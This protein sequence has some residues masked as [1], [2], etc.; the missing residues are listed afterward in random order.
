MIL[1]DP[2]PHLDAKPPKPGRCLHDTGLLQK[3]P[4]PELLGV[5][6]LS[7]GKSIGA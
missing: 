4:H 3:N 1:H 7:L 2:I 6:I 5:Q